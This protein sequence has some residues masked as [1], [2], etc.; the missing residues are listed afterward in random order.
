M[1]DFVLN[2][3]NLIKSDEFCIIDDEFCIK[4]AGLY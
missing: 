3:M 4:I 1:M 2:M